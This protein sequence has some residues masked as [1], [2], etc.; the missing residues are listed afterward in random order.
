MG[1]TTLEGLEAK[2]RKKASRIIVG[3]FR[4]PEAPDGSWFGRV[5]LAMP[6]EEWP[7]DRGKP[8]LPLCQLN[9]TEMPFVPPNLN[10]VCLITVFISAISLSA[11]AENGDGWQLRAYPSLDGWV[12]IETP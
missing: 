2:L 10:D 4:P 11:D 3:G 1:G 8:M 7:A 12:Q 6:D 9:L 5:R